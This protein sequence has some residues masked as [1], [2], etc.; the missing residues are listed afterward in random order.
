MSGFEDV[1]FLDV[2]AEGRLGA[3]PR[4][5]VDWGF[6]GAGVGAGRP[7]VAAEAHADCG[8]QYFVLSE[9]LIF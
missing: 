6:R 7:G 2:G 8:L 3:C 9:I 1:P 5:E 4:A